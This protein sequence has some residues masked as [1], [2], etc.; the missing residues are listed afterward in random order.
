MHVQETP[1]GIGSLNESYLHRAVKQWLVKPGD[2]P[3]ARG[4][5]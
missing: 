5:N 4:E 3:E 2:L 1:P